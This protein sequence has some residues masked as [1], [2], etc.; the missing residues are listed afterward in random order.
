MENFQL[1]RTNILL[2]GQMKWDLIL[3]KSSNELIVKDLHLTPISRNIPYT[4]QSQE[5]LLNYSH[6]DN[7]K[8]YY[9]RM[10]NV[11]YNHGVNTEF[12]HN[13]PIIVDNGA[14][15]NPYNDVCDMGCRRS[16]HYNIYDKQF[17]F[18]CPLWIEHMDGDIVF[19]ISI[20]SPKMSNPITTKKL[21]IKKLYGD[22]ETTPFEKYFN[23]YIKY[24]GIDK[25]S[26]NVMCVNFDGNNAHIVGMDVET[27]NQVTK[28][29]SD[30]ISV[31]TSRERPVMEFDNV[32]ISNFYNNHTIVNQLFN[33]NLCFNLSDIMSLSLEHTLYGKSFSISIDV[34]IGDK[35]LTLKDFDTEYEFIKKPVIYGEDKNYNVLNYL[36][37][38]RCIDLICENKLSQPICH[39]SLCGNNDYIFNLYSGFGG[40]SVVD[41]NDKTEI[42]L[43]K[44]QHG[45]TPAIDYTEHNKYT[46]NIGWLNRFEFNEW[47]DFYLFISRLNDHK[48]EMSVFGIS[49]YTNDIKY[50]KKP[51]KPL[52]FCGLYVHT[53]ILIKIKNN[54]SNYVTLNDN[55]VVIIIDDVLL[56]VTDILDNFPYHRVISKLDGVLSELNNT[57]Q[58]YAKLN[59]FTN[60]VKSYVSPSL[61]KIDTSLNAVVCE[62][63]STKTT[64]ITYYKD[65]KNSGI[66]LRYGGKLKPTFA[67]RRTMYYKDYIS[68]EVRTNGVSKLQLSVYGRYLSNVFEPKYKSIGYYSIRS[69]EMDYENLPT[70]VVSEYPLGVNLTA[71]PEYN[72]FNINSVICL[73]PKIEFVLYK[74]SDEDSISDKITNH[75]REIYGS[76]YVK[77]IETLYN[78][79]YDWDYVDNNTNKYRYNITLKLK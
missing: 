32:L 9:S 17:E 8:T 52:Y 51:N 42:I 57:H 10:K 56:F 7:V 29:V 35:K 20:K 76:K 68:D 13:W 19:E 31:M 28:D 16:K 69:Q 24:V 79:T 15:I 74:N 26:D 11:F 43:S 23:E 67:N 3:D 27:G 45:K 61:I 49:D 72:W 30:I 55:F 1:Y 65:N 18:F 78:I 58:H 40:Y 21:T 12:L 47:K 34:Y 77:Y 25:G 66:V 22:E 71:S 75:L 39:W 41:D 59:D 36:A 6:R 33:I 62:G 14:V 73:K 5:N 54:Y 46:N 50:S 64:E 38:D 60:I 44:Y 4:L 2:G 63:P 70:V 37:D 48:T 53:N